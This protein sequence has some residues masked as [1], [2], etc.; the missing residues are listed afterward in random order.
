VPHR[1]R[2]DGCVMEVDRPRDVEDGGGLERAPKPPDLEAVLRAQV[3][4]A[5]VDVDRDPSRLVWGGD[6]GPEDAT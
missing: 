6:A 1:G 4:L 5:F 3:D 2:R